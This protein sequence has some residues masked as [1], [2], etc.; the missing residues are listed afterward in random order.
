MPGLVLVT[1]R[2]PLTAALAEA[3]AIAPP[4]IHIRPW[5]D[6][7]D[8]SSMVDVFHAARVIDGTG[9]ELTAGSLAADLRS[10]GIRPQDTILIAEAEDGGVVGWSR[11]YDFGASPDEGRLLMHSGHVR[12][13]VRRR[14][15]GRALLRGAQVELTRMR[16]E[17][18]DASGTTCG[19]HAWVFARNTS[20]IALLEAA[21]YRRL[22]FVIEMARSLENVPSIDLPSGLT[23]RPATDADRLP[24]ARALN[25]AMRD[26][27]GWPVW[28]DEQVATAFEHP[29]RGQLDVWQVAWSGDEV[30]GGVL[31]Y[32]DA[33]ENEAMHR[34]RGYTESIFTIRS[35]R[36]HGVASA[37][38]ARNLRLLAERGMTE[39]ALSV[40]TENPTGALGL[41]ERHGFREADRLIVFRKDIE[42]SP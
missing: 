42:P 27:R 11:A 18:P 34:R 35:W 9:W 29:T 15:L 25:A 32:V 5:R 23:T 4:G 10:V 7:A 22:R 41:Y 16:A 26:H 30:V 38:I 6:D 36:G 1:D 28:S 14:G 13:D 40:D 21:G 17:R 39:A 20:T 3:R 37:L 8:F 12:P 31:G 19:Y 33:D 2:A 24:I